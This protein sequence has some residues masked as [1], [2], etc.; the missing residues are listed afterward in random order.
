MQKSSIVII[1]SPGAIGDAER[2][3]ESLVNGLQGKEHTV[4]VLVS[5]HY[6]YY[7]SLKTLFPGSVYYIGNNLLEIFCKRSGIEHIDV[8]ST[9]IS[10]GYHSLF[11]TILLRL[12]L[13]PSSARKHI[14]IKHGW[15]NNTLTG[16]IMT[17][18]DKTLSIFCSTIVTVNKN[19]LDSM[20]CFLVRPVYIE[21]GI[22]IPSAPIGQSHVKGSLNA[23]RL[24]MVGRIEQEKRFDLGIEISNKLSERFPI[25]LH[26]I[27]TGS[28][29]KYLK[30]MKINRNLTVN[31]YGYLPKDNIPYC[32][33]DILLIT[34][35]TEGSPL[36]ALEALSNGKFVISTDVGNMLD[37][38]SDGRGTV[39]PQ[40][41][42]ETRNELIIAFVESIEKYINF[43]QHRKFMVSQNAREYISLKHSLDCMINKYK[44]IL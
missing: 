3:A 31:F 30:Q 20:K 39:I 1:L 38:L 32:N 26:I 34:S 25:E 43:S 14:D 4:T 9:I 18:T 17:A 42:S 5:H 16:R 37:L 12:R 11:V 36:V 28:C 27:G 40:V 10:N 13:F 29:E 44:K 22:K 23:V 19:M 6:T 33:I 2:Y 21:T 15:V 35:T 8:N 7:L 24:G 41:K